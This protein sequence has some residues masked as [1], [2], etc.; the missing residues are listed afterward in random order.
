[1]TRSSGLQRAT[2]ASRNGHA[3]TTSRLRTSEIQLYFFDD[4]STAFTCRCLCSS[5]VPE[6]LLERRL[7]HTL[8]RAGRNPKTRDATPL[9]CMP[10]AVQTGFKKMHMGC[11][12]NYGPFLGTLNIRCHIIIGIQ[13]GTIILTT[14]HVKFP[15]SRLR[16]PSHNPS[17][18]HVLAQTS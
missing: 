16:S 3:Q 7:Y 10:A 17:M 5:W 4:S 14:T 11:S 15:I 8:T 6:G 12:Q 18:L 1:M 13:Q 9:P 2:L